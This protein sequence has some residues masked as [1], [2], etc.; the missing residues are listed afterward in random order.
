M[1]LLYLTSISLIF[2][3]I[4]QT[5]SSQNIHAYFSYIFKLHISQ[6][7]YIHSHI[8]TTS[9]KIYLFLTI[10]ILFKRYQHS[11]KSLSY[12]RNRLLIHKALFL[13]GTKISYKSP[14]WKAKL[15]IFD[16][17]LKEHYMEKII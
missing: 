4:F 14:T 10:F 16:L 7:I 3:Y 11:Y 2:P 9:H 8:N 6:S 5:H 1:Y 12:G 17:K 15:F 13:E